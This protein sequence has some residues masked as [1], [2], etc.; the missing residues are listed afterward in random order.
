[1]PQHATHATTCKHLKLPRKPAHDPTH[2][3][4]IPRLNRAMA[5]GSTWPEAP[6]ESILSKASPPLSSCELGASPCSRLLPP[7]KPTFL[8]T[9][10]S[11]L[12][13]VSI[14]LRPAPMEPLAPRSRMALLSSDPDPVSICVSL[15]SCAPSPAADESMIALESWSLDSAALSRPAG[16][17]PPRS[18]SR[19][20]APAHR[21]HRTLASVRCFACGHSTRTPCPRTRTRPCGMHARCAWS[22]ALICVSTQRLAPNREGSR[23]AAVAEAAGEKLPRGASTS[24]AEGQHESAGHCRGWGGTPLGRHRGERR[25]T[26]THTRHSHGHQRH[27][28]R[29]DGTPHPHPHGTMQQKSPRAPASGL[30]I[31][32]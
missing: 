2:D 12:R 8:C 28:A 13:R 30:M 21:R 20:P 24:E 10:C 29:H 25:E 1:M 18:D 16:S 32:S 19:N 4:K 22:H 27:H 9:A 15:A 14:S 26:H 23:R 17:T 6:P 31:Q 7:C 11:R 3:S 5:S